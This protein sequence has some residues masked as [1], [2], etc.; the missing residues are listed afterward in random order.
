MTAQALISRADLRSSLALACKVV[1]RRNTT[2]IL[3]NVAIRSDAEGVTLQATDMDIQAT[4]RM[5]GTMADAGFGV[6]IPAHLLKDIERKAPDSED[7]T[8]T[9][10]DMEA[11]QDNQTAALDFGRVT[12]SA[13]GLPVIDWPELQVTGK[14]NA[15]VSIPRAALLDALTFCARAIS[16]EE[17]R[18]Y[19]NGIFLS[20]ADADGLPVLRMVA[21]D[22]HRMAVKDLAAADVVGEFADMPG[23]IVPRKT[24]NFLIDVLKRKGAPDT[25]QIVVNF[26]K[27]RFVSGNVDVVSKLI[28][29]TF[30]DYQCVIPT[31]NDKV[32]TVDRLELVE[33]VKAVTCI[34]SE[35]GRA[36]K[37]T[38]AD[39]RL[40][41][42]VDNPDAGKAHSEMAV[43]YDDAPIEI[44]LN[45]RYLLDEL[46]AYE[47]ATI[48][49]KLAECGS[50]ILIYA[51]AAALERSVLMPMRV[52]PYPG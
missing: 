48:T 32:L 42:D 24:V 41:L 27:C 45:S 9:A 18:Y 46:E 8:I 51:D 25:A 5:G 35:R 52:Y 14:I 22:G 37:L 26:S 4:F 11:G 21:T 2:P 30:P 29:G 1:E 23:V 47:G 40:C 36:V 50:P 10:G 20:V 7:V 19:L 6:T 3:S 49:I 15:D 44:G 33:R 28:D 34:S 17:T 13:N 12:I 38:A 31:R 16:V 39:G 43:S